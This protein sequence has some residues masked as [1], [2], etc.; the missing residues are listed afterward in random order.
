MKTWP[1]LA[2]PKSLNKDTL[3]RMTFSRG[4]ELLEWEQHRNEKMIKANWQFKT[5]DE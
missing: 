5:E 2:L 1:S 3:I 4:R